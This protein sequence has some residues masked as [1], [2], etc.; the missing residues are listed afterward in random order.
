[1]LHSTIASHK[2]TSERDY[3]TGATRITMPCLAG[4]DVSRGIGEITLM[5]RPGGAI[6]DANDQPI[7]IEP[8]ETLRG[9]GT[10]DGPSY[11][12]GHVNV[13]CEIIDHL[14]S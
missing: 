2:I 6:T 5:V 12:V 4:E 13:P 10:L 3:I 7:T 9:W 11:Q 14:R 1:M 8:G